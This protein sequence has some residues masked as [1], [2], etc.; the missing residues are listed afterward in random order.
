MTNST[1]TLSHRGTKAATSPMRVDMELYFEALENRY[2]AATNPDGKFPMNVAEN[3]LCW[4]MLREKIAASVQREIPEWVS[5]YGN[6]AGNDDFRVAAAG[7]LSEHLFGVP[8]EKETL[9]FSSGLTSVIDLT[10]FLL[11][12][13]GEVALIPAPS[14]PV[15]T[16]DIGVKAGLKRVDIPTHENLHELKEG[17]PLTLPQLDQALAEV[18][19]Q[20]ERCS[21]LI[22]TTPDN[23]TG[24]IYSQGQL[25]AFA[26]WC[27]AHEIHLVVNEIYGLTLVDTAHPEI[28]EDYGQPRSFQSFAQVMAQRKSPYLHLWYSISKD[29]GL[30]GF[31]VGMVHSYNEEFMAGY[32][33]INMTHSVSNFTQWALQGVFEDRAFMADYLQKM[34]A[35]LTTSYIIV[36]RKLKQ[37]GLAYSPS[38]GSLFVWMDLSELLSAPTAKAEETLWLE[39][40]EQAGLLLTPTNGFGHA[41]KGYYRMVISYLSHEELEVAMERFGEFVE[42][43]K[44]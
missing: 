7:Y 6:P 32:T 28:S 33:N 41:Q 9:A 35:A 3:T 29:L 11:G 30:S 34:Q 10:A 22:L 21:M 38:Y 5:G 42:R 15:Y 24:S 23:P 18:K 44:V 27:I 19:A 13:P 4:P 43:K 39:I 31:R 8:V 12:N 17:L 25:Q 2:D 16:S 26:D 14:Y 37:L 1:P 36:A 20:G 40:Y